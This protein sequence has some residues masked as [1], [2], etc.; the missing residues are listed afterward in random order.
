MKRT[1]GLLI[2]LITTCALVFGAGAKEQV[3]QTVQIKEEVTQMGPLNSNPL[4]DVRIRQAIAYAIDMDAIIEGLLPGAVAADSLTPNNEWKVAGLEAYSYNPGKA[5]QLLKDAGWDSA[6]V[7][8]L[9]Y[10][11]GDQQTVDLMAT[12]Q[13]Y[14]ADVGIKVVP[15]KLEGDLN[16]QLWVAPK[17]PVNGTSAVAWDLAYAG[18]AVVSQYEYYNRFHT[19]VATNSHTP[20]NAE[21]D[22]L[23]DAVNKTNKVAEQK[24]YFGKIQQFENK[25]LPTIP[26][27]YQQ[28]FVI[29]N[30]RLTRSGAEYGNEQ[31]AYDWKI[32]TWD[33]KPNADGRKVMKANGGPIQ[34]FEAPFVNPAQFTSQKVLF[35]RLIVADGGLQNF[36]GQLAKD[37]SVSADGLTISFTMKDNIYWHDGSPIT[38]QD[39]KFTWELAAKVSSVNVLFSG[40]FKTIVGYAD[41]NTKK[42]NELSGI[43]VKDNTV[44]FRFASIFP[45]A[46]VALS[47]LPPL[48]Q[49]YLG[50]ADPLLI[51]QA[52]YWQNPIG[53]GP[54]MVKEVRMNNYCVLVPFGKYHEGRGIIDEIQLYPSGESDP[55]LVKN[56]LAGQLDYGWTKSLTDANALKGVAGLKVTPYD[57]NYTRLIYVNKFAK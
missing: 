1:T 6:K 24:E 5:K 20:G 56:A 48:P 7:L 39:V 29:E 35:D 53:S 49:K 34:F 17:D 51:Q 12:V 54:Y 3:T 38:A 42:T 46:L 33:I 50:A 15:R 9:V 27:Y 43:T 44:T 47:Q 10:Y 36:R 22:A 40:L 57:M 2:I 13:A 41:F 4:S 19:G 28:L 52:S 23:L 55:N 11:Y 31:Y 30:N 18:L 21:L 26:L 8:D 37:Y 45:N 32:Q 14:L 25:Y 16:S